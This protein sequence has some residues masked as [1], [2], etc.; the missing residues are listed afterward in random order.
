[1][2]ASA[3]N[4]PAHRQILLYAAAVMD[5]S[6]V[7]EIRRIRRHGGNDDRPRSTWH[8][9][10]RLCEMADAL[11]RDNEGGWEIYFGVNPRIA[12]GKR[13][14]KSIVIARTLFVD[15]DDT[16]LDE[17]LARIRA[18]GLPVPT[19]VILSGHGVHAY[20][21]LALPMEDLKE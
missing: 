18:V 20:W 14:D 17:A 2:E 1:M 9:A 15:F 6:D 12:K 11:R 19:L 21:R 8:Y 10:A 13:G 4:I 7:V 16:T 5:P 3:M